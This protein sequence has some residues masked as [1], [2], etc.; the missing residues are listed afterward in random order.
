MRA[1]ILAE[2][3]QT[4]DN[5]ILVATEQ[6][7]TDLQA[8]VID[9]DVQ[10]G[11]RLVG[12]TFQPPVVAG[13]TEADLLAYSAQAR[14]RRETAGTTALDMQVPTDE[15]TQAVLTAAYVQASADPEFTVD[16]WK[17]G[18]GTYVALSAADIIAISAAVSAH[19]QA[20]FA[21]NATVDAGILAGT[22]TTFAQI[23]AAYAA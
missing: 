21:L 8:V 1:A 19:I 11:W 16:P 12:S 17:V 13:P 7:A 6:D 9:D 23:D 10:I 2:D 3:G 14:W 5:V 4:V 15:R 20:C 18:P 22:I